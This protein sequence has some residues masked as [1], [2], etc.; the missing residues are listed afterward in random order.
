[1][2][3]TGRGCPKA[4][5]VRPR[6]STADLTKRFAKRKLAVGTKVEIRVLGTGYIGKVVTLTVRANK[7][8]LLRTTCLPPG[9]DRPQ[10]CA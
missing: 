10:R 7:V 3:C 5:N 9:A 8:P 6:T 4:A 2:R 1:M